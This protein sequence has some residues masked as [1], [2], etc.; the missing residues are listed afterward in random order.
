MLW[1]LYIEDDGTEN[2]VDIQTSAPASMD[3]THI[4]ITYANGLTT[5]YRDGERAGTTI[6]PD[7]FSNAVG[8]FALGVNYGWNAPFQ[9]QVDEFIVYDYALNS[10]D[11]NGAAINNLTEPFW[12]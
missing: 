6:R 1:S 8:K 10:L 11:I 12:F 2:W 5:L 7:F 4:A 9:G 3:W